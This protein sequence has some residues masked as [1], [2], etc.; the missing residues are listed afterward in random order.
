MGNISLS[1]VEF[2][3]LDRAVIN[4]PLQ[5]FV[6]VH[7]AGFF[8]RQRLRYFILIPIVGQHRPIVKRQPEHTAVSILSHGKFSALGIIRFAGQR[9]LLRLER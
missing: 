1:L 3:A 2:R 7:P 6:G 9:A 4:K 5:K 8:R